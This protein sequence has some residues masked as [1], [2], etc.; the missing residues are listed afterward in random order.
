MAKNASGNGTASQVSSAAGAAP[1]AP[2]GVG[3]GTRVSPAGEFTGDGHNMKRTEAKIAKILEGGTATED[4]GE[5]MDEAD[6]E[7]AENEEDAEDEHDQIPDESDE[8]AE[9]DDDLGEDDAETDEDEKPAKDTK[10]TGPSDDDDDE[11]YLSQLK[12]PQED[13]S[14]E[15]GESKDGAEKDGQADESDDDSIIPLRLSNEIETEYEGTLADTFK[16]INERTN[17]RFKKFEQP[18]RVL[19]DVLERQMRVEQ[20]RA[21]GE[22][23]AA[24]TSINSEWPE[25]ARVFGQSFS[26]QTE[27]Q[28]QAFRAVVVRAAKLRNAAVSDKKNPRYI[29][30]DTAIKTIVRRDHA[31]LIAKAESKKKA[32]EPKQSRNVRFVP[33]T[34]REK[35]KRSKGGASGI[36]SLTHAIKDKFGAYLDNE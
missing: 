36:D 3:N 14:E 6:Y 31:G 23:R 27:A 2:K 33:A 17:A 30:M 18:I 28:K 16:A 32:A 8:Q 5:E 20:L 19:A 21:I 11:T 10:K 34:Q 12:E 13:D 25:L 7:A 26:S 4:A 1:A 22:T 35:V 24:F 9:S 15:S 29:S